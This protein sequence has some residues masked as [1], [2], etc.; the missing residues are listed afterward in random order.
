[1]V[2]DGQH[3]NDGSQWLLLALVILSCD[4]RMEVIDRWDDSPDGE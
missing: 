1:M 4:S 3:G 2:N